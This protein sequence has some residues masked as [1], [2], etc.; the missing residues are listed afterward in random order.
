MNTFISPP[1]PHISIYIC[2]YIQISIHIPQVSI[3]IHIFSCP[4]T[5]IPPYTNLHISVRLPT[6]IFPL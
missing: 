5:R 4:Y 3:F 6:H 2:M 1:S